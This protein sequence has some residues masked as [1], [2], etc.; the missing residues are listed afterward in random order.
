MLPVSRA[1]EQTADMEDIYIE[2]CSGKG[3]HGLGNDYHGI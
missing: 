2:D 3:N 1:V